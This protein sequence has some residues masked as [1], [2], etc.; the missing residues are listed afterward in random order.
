MRRM[1]TMNSDE[2]KACWTRVMQRLRAELGE[3]LY[4]SWFARMELDGR[5][6]GRTD[7]G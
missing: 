2:V 7:T 5:N 1:M 4:N 6:D 3:D